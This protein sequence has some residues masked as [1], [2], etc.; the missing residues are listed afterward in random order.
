[1]TLIEIMI[2]L[3]DDEVLNEKVP[4]I[5]EKRKEAPGLIDEDTESFDRVMS[6]F[7]M[8]EEKIPYN[9]NYRCIAFA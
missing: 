1:M 9:A 4:G 6:A 8:A 3:T 5:Q 7:K 2:N